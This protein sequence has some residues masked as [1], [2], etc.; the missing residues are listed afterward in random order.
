MNL[1]WN[2]VFLRKHI[3]KGTIKVYVNI[4][5]LRLRCYRPFDN[6]IRYIKNVHY[7]AQSNSWLILRKH[8]DNVYAIIDDNMTVKNASWILETTAL[9]FYVWDQEIINQDDGDAHWLQL[10]ERLSWNDVDLDLRSK[11]FRAPSIERLKEA[12]LHVNICAWCPGDL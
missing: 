8:R 6:T 10:S 1:F 12:L 2:Y 4:C 5:K 9:R 7:I 3:M 11:R